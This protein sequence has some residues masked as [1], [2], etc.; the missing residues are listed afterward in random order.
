MIALSLKRSFF[1]SF[2]V[3]TGFVAA[4]QRIIQITMKYNEIQ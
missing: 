1:V 4:L 3:K 2:V